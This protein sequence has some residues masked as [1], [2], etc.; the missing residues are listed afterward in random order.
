MTRMTS[1]DYWRLCEEMS[2]VHAALLIVGCDPSGGDDD[3]DYCYVEHWA[4]PARPYGYEAAKT[5]IT[6]ALRKGNISGRLAYSIVINR[7]AGDVGMAEVD[8]SRVD[9]SESTVDV[10]S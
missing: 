10:E 6:N 9:P 3:G 4:P 1:L 2:V 7:D 8:E 5:A